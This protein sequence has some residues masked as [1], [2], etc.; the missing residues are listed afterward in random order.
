[1]KLFHHVKQT[2]KSNT[3]PLFCPYNLKSRMEL[4]EWSQHPI[5]SNDSVMDKGKT[6]TTTHFEYMKCL[7]GCCAAWHD[8]QC[9]YVG[10]VN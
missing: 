8:G 1:M 5:D 3:S 9:H 2:S 4:Q 7:Q 10:T 6:A